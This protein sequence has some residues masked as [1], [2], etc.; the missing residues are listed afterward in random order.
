MVTAHQTT[1]FVSS[2]YQELITYRKAALDA[3]W[4]SD[5]YP[6]GMERE[7]YAMPFS[8]SASSRRMVDEAVVYIGVFSHRYGVVTAEELRRAEERGIPI[9]PFIA[10]EPLNAEDHEPDPER[11]RLLE[12][13][14]QELKRKYVVATF[15]TPEE[16]GTK[17]YRSLVA[18]RE[19]GKLPPPEV[20]TTPHERELA[21]IP[22]PPVPYYAHPYLLGA[23]GF[24]GR[25]TE[26]AQLDAWAHASE[27][28][29]IVEAIGGAGKSALTW[30]WAQTHL[31]VALPNRAGVIWWSFYESNATMGAFL[32][33]GLAYLTQRP[34][35]DCAHL[36]RPQREEQ[37]LALLTQRPIV[38]VLDGLERLLVAYHRMDAAHLTDIAVEAQPRACTDP[39][40]GAFLRTL[41]RCTASK[42]LVT[43]RLVPADLQD[44]AGQLL[45]GV[46]HL[47]LYGLTAE[48][49]IS[50]KEAWVD[51]PPYAYAVELARARVCLK[52]L[53]IPEPSLPR[54]DPK[55]A[56]SAPYEAE[57]RALIEDL[58]KE[59]ADDEHEIASEQ[60]HSP[61]LISL[62]A[63][64]VSRQHWWAPWTWGRP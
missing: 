2:V 35:E 25:R 15:D 29:L 40:D 18:M 49:A 43:S 9:L 13:L 62:Q 57:I 3:V 44:R 39:R 17:V 59:S 61:D 32:T 8:T 28:L 45:Q 30:D 60:E 47:P 48:D 11:A 51:G 53:G 7:D 27:P 10:T 16:L 26:L 36:S 6:L 58:R 63:P 14:K 52:A 21:V 5:Y 20:A 41:T 34:E 1:I 46:R 12:E 42:I 50:L 4:R 56:P 54:F 64:L 55:K 33:R 23:S 22:T 24:V 38:L 37:L 19:D 31:D